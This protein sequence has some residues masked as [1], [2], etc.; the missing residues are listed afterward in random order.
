MG[1]LSVLHKGRSGDTAM[2]DLVANSLLEEAS[3]SY[4]IGRLQHISGISK[5]LPDSLSKLWAPSPKL[6]QKWNWPAQCARPHRQEKLGFCKSK[7][8][9][10]SSD[11]P[12]ADPATVTS[13]MGKN[14]VTHP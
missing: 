8:G 13:I 5:S 4:M 1:V 2:N 9:K 7:S 10:D 12:M 14:G 3:G 6:F 11:L